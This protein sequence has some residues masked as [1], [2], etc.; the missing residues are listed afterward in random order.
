MHGNIDV[1]PLAPPGAD[2]IKQAIV[3]VNNAGCRNEGNRSDTVA[4]GNIACEPCNKH[5]KGELA[6]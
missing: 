2:V 5:S 1:K 4:G 3:V 6:I